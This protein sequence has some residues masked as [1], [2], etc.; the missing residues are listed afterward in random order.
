MLSKVLVVDDDL[1]IRRVFTLLL[2]DVVQIFSVSSGREAIESIQN[3]KFDLVF[4]DIRMDDLDG[5][6]TLKR[7]K[8]T[9]PDLEVIMISG[10]KD[11]S[12]AAE[13]I[14]NGAHSYIAKPLD[15]DELRLLIKKLLKV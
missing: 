5:I 7:I 12:I 11:T 6:E 8:K 4:L 2:Q 10:V 15:V 13:A 14:E 9:N 1:S 3:E